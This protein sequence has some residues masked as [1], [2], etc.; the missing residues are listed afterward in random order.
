MSGEG[1]VTVAVEARS[2]ARALE[3]A[4]ARASALLTELRMAIIRA[5][6]F[7]P[8]GD[9]LE[10]TNME[11]ANRT[12]READAVFGEARNF[13]VEATATALEQLPHVEALERG[14]EVLHRFPE[15]TVDVML[16]LRLVQMRGNIEAGALLVDN[17]LFLEWNIILRS[18]L[19]AIEDVTFL[20]A[21]KKF[22][23]ATTFE[24]FQSSFFDE[25][26]DRDCELSR[27]PSVSVQ[28]PDIA[29]VLAETQKQFGLAGVGEPIDKQ[30]RKLHRVCSGSVHG[31]GASILRAYYDESAQRG[32]WQGGARKAWRT[33]LERTV[34]HCATAWAVSATGVAGHGRWWDR[35]FAL[36]A[37]RLADRMRDA[38]QCGS[39]SFSSAGRE[40]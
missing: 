19:D 2:G 6:S 16:G 18:M 8:S 21:P 25:D 10:M 9:Q 24:K 20:I 4:L 14:G 17:G 15:K 31:R 3:S 39:N 5:L 32:L 23:S 36:A 30:L 40:R 35:D 33:A 7:V 22:R 13:I 38:A 11:V 29:K 28:R 34:L 37:S 12:S 26:I 27:R 1:D